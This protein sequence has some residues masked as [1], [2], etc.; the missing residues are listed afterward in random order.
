MEIHKDTVTINALCDSS[1]R[2]VKQMA[3]K[4]QLS[5]SFQQKGNVQTIQGDVR[6]LKQILVNLLSNAVKFTPKGGSIGIEAVAEEDEG[7]IHFRVWDTGIGI[8][9]EQ[10]SQLFKPFVQLDSKLSRQHVGTGLGLALVSRLSEMHGGSVT[11]ESEVGKGS[12]FTISLPIGQKPEEIHDPFLSATPGDQ[13]A[14][15]ASATAQKQSMCILLAE[16][17][18][19]NI[20]LY[21][22][23]LAIKGF[24]VVV[25]RNGQE[26]ID[27]T[28]EIHPDIILMDIQM[29]RMDG[30]EAM[31]HIRAHTAFRE[32]PIVAL[33]ALAMPGDRERCIEA[34]ANEY[35][36]KPVSLRGLLQTIQS[37]LGPANVS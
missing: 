7:I 20:E 25:A 22:D 6:R 5:V 14:N 9:D 8:H 35:M 36:S 17:N 31:K 23:Y 21:S 1:I 13:S 37:L 18:E 15:I 10:A 24:R 11:I 16:D 26:A 3:A 34:G 29:P 30:L 2:F 12:R 32:L 28:H 27:R 19:S 33:T 4:K